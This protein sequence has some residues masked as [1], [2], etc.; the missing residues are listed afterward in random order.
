MYARRGDR[1]ELLPREEQGCVHQWRRINR[2]PA[3]SAIAMDGLGVERSDSPTNQPL[4]A[5]AAAARISSM[6]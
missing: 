5:A 3:A 4:I 2:G 1:P 6:P